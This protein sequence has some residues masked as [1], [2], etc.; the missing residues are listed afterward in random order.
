MPRRPAWRDTF[1][2]LSRTRT[3]FLVL[4]DRPCS[5]YATGAFSGR[6]R[7][8]CAVNVKLT[9][10]LAIGAD[11]LVSAPLQLS[12]AFST[13]PARLLRRQCQTGFGRRGEGWGCRPPAPARKDQH[14]RGRAFSEP[15]FIVFIGVLALSW[16]HP[17][18]N[19]CHGQ[20]R[21]G[22]AAFRRQ[23]AAGRCLGCPR[24]HRNL[25]LKYPPCCGSAA[26]WSARTA[27]SGVTQRYRL[28]SS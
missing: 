2:P 5:V 16:P 18:L 24:C 23:R 14:K 27:F 6:R 21:L 9:T 17:R 19:P 28:V 26:S 1:V 25:R 7:R 10:Q 22:S 3:P 13:G 12:P 8:L 11:L 15:S 4:Q 20:S